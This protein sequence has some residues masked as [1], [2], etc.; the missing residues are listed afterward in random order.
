VVREIVHRYLA[1]QELESQRQRELQAIIDLA[2]FR[3]EIQERHGI[4]QADLLAEVR[5]ERE[6]DT[7][8]VWRGEA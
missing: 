6:E 7:E 4:Y 2:H 5:A 8:R 1:E 3:K